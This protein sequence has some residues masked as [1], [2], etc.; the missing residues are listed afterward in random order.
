[1]LNGTYSVEFMT[2]NGNGSG[3]VVINNGTIRG[4]DSSMYYVGTMTEKDD[5]VTAK[6][7]A[8]IHSQ[9][10]GMASVFGV[11]EVNI[12]LTG[13]LTSIKDSIHLK[14]NA[15]EAPDVEFKALLQKLCD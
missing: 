7:R 6:V 1:M 15:Q 5:E 2:E 11:D 4:G 13:K 14:G 12:E 8:A 3:V 10:I 9:V